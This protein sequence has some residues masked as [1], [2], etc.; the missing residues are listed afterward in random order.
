MRTPEEFKKQVKDHNITFWPH[1]ACSFCKV[2]VGYEF[3]NEQAFFNSS[4]ECGMPPSPLQP[5]TWEQIAN[6]YNQQTNSDIIKKMDE[7]WKFTK[8]GEIA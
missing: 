1:H 2:E 5:R 4:C 8:K 7:F 6:A 3:H